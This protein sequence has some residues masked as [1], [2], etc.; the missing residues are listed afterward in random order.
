[1][2]KTEKETTQPTTTLEM[3]ENKTL[4]VIFQTKG[5]IGKSTLAMT[6]IE[7][8]QTTK[9]YKP[10]E[11]LA[12]DCDTKTKTLS[13]A[14]YGAVYYPIREADAE[15]ASEAVLNQ[16]VEDIL[17]SKAKRVILDPGAGGF[18]DIFSFFKTLDVFSAAKEYAQRQVIIHLPINPKAYSETISGAELSLE[19]FGIEQ[20]RYILWIL[21]HDK[22]MDD[23]GKT[24][25]ESSLVMKYHDNIDAI[26]TLPHISYTSAAIGE[27]L[28]S[29]K[30]VSEYIDS[31]ANIMSKH[32][33]G[34]YY[35]SVFDQI[36]QAKVL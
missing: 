25:K 35:S 18:D 4:E 16:I 20:V 28:A 36:E 2:E 21:E 17:S 30:T 1:M 3:T 34:R 8:Y 12:I 23:I 11:I 22:S 32:S 26:I 9:G 5:G 13:E 24:I 19:A 14:N 7:Y 29:K 15:K 33:L 27:Q 10:G 31:D 6:L